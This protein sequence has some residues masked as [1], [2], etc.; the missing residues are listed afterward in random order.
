MKI[1]DDFR[2]DLD[3]LEGDLQSTINKMSEWREVYGD[4]AHL[5]TVYDYSGIYL[6]L[7]YE[8]EETPS[9]KKHREMIEERELKKKDAL[10]KK[11]EA[12]ERKEYA[13]LKKKFGG[14]K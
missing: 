7:K 1:W 14:D 9:E 4:T 13:R 2:I 11:K 3:D 8:R 6:L 5:R 12:K 10:L